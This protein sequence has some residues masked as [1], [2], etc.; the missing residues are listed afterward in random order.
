VQRL[1][2][3]V[4]TIFLLSVSPF[5]SVDV[6]HSMTLVNG[7]SS[8]HIF[9]DITFE[10]GITWQ[11]FNGESKDRY[12]IETMT[13]GV[14]FLDYNND[15]LLDLY[16]V[17]GGETP[18]GTSNFP[19]RNALY[20][21]LGGEKFK[22]V[23]ARAGVDRVPF[24]S[25][26]VAAADYDNDG[27][28]DLFVTGYPA[29]A[30]FHNNR[31]GT[32]KNVTNS[33]GVANLGNLAASAAWFDYDRDGLLDLFICNYAK[34]SFTDARICEVAPGLRAYCEPKIY[35]GS[36]PTLYH[37]NGN[38]FS[39]VTTKS[40]LRKLIGRS[41]GVVS[42]DANADGWS[43]LFVA[44]DASPNLL[45]LNKKNGTF[46]DIGI[47]A[48]ISF[49]PDGISLAGMGVDAG[50]INGD[51]RLDFT[52]TNF[53]DEY[54]SL[55]IQRGQTYYENATIES[56]LA[57]FTKKYVGWGTS[58]ID[59]DNDGD[60][61]L[62]T[63]NGHVE[64]QIEIQRASV[65]YK[66][67]PLLLKNN[68]HAAFSD[69]KALAGPVFSN[70]YAARGLARGDFDNDGDTDVVF[71]N[72]NALPVLLRNNLGQDV[73]WIGID[74]VGNVSNRDSIGTLLTLKV[75]EN[76]FVRWI[77]GGSSYLSSHDRRVIFGLGAQKL[78]DKM[79]LE[80]MWP[81]G[82]IQREEG[83]RINRYNKILERPRRV[84][85]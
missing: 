61:D 58:F 30:L 13:G 80:I 18:N 59:Y 68:G 28:E 67:S 62:I 15:G 73:P 54:H 46:A 75:G 38:G 4:K 6:V 5:L 41:L 22:D 27:Y 31:D 70:S 76:K 7:S 21:N 2:L 78:S 32:F 40:R 52:V 56:G 84:S 72:L 64:P 17:N 47:Q 23:S 63:V 45:L 19:I 24:Y 83:L 53:S 66:Q 57:S 69:E 16:L 14:A 1:V 3:A 9:S 85:R 39:E 71:I 48:G 25:M 60:L 37:N 77:T 8:R 79:I 44:R 12:L 55:F 81:S 74:L 49:N 82:L 42:V 65:S 34:F 35:D 50:D 26:G 11:Q 20:E 33:A 36:S 43:D 29:C 10:S 51:G